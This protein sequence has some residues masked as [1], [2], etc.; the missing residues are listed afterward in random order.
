MENRSL[1]IQ[2]KSETEV[3]SYDYIDVVREIELTT[4]RMDAPGKLVFSCVEQGPLKIFEGSSVEYVVD[5]K[6]LFKGYIFT[7]ERAHDGETSYTAYD[8]LRYLKASAS[9]V[10]ENM[11]LS[12]IIG[13]IAAD[14]GLKTGKLEDPGYVFPSLIKEDEGCLDIIF[15]ALSETITRTGR[16][17]L[18]CD[19]AGELTLTE[20]KNLVTGT[21]IGDGSLASDY[22]YKRDIDSDTYNRI[23]LVRKNEKSGRTDVYIHE[24]TETIR[25][26]GLLQYYAEVDENLNE[27]QIDEMCG[28]Y[29]SYYN[30]VL[31]TLKLEAIGVPGIRAGMILPVKFKDIEVLA[32][33]RLLLAEKVTHKW[34]GEFHTMDI[35]VKSFEQ[36]G[37]AEIV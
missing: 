30:R 28:A 9:Y 10:F 13:Q 2:V 18:F 33:S 3:A 22:T 34:D 1:V 7:V 12:Q 20:A 5:G 26:W 29:L 32:G 35:E 15:D 21:L 27:A 31:Q 4:N 17:F 36:F 23:K 37:G 11:S 8:Q 6:K 14:F 25:K 16:I 19:D 24:D